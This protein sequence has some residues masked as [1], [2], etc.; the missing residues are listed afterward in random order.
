MTTSS[1]AKTR[2]IHKKRDGYLLIERD[3]QARFLSTIESALWRLSGLMPGENN[4][5]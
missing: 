4:G 5:K 2:R 3:G 1:N